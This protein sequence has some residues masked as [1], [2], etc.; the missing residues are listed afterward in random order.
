MSGN[1]MNASFFKGARLVDFTGKQSGFIQM[2]RF[3]REFIDLVRKTTD[4]SKS[5]VVLDTGFGGRY[6]GP[7]V[8]RD[9][10]NLTGDNPL[11]GPNH[12][13]GQRFPIIQGVYFTCCIKG[14]NKGV[15]AGLKEGVKPTSD[16]AQILR[17]I[18]VDICSYNLVPS[19]LVAA[20]AGWKVLGIVLPEGT[21]LS[22]S[23]IQEINE[24]TGSK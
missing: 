2:K 12:P 7:L 23:Q 10:I 13:I 19:M 8:A 9:H 11:V 15:V 1:N 6:A 16:D 4:G 17:A 3:D 21:S 18:G 5:V 14:A 22:T 24:L 20:H